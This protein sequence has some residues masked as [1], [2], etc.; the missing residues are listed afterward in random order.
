MNH[1]NGR[2]SIESKYMM[3]VFKQREGEPKVIWDCNFFSAHNFLFIMKCFKSGIHSE[4]HCSP[5]S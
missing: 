2:E 4:V 3:M 1:I 5:Y